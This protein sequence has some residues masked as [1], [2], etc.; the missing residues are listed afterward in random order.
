M[1]AEIQEKYRALL[2][3]FLRPDPSLLTIESTRVTVRISLRSL[4]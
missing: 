2:N 1:A 3:E 4:L